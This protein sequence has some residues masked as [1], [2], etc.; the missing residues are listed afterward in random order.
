MQN[1]ANQIHQSGHHGHSHQPQDAFQVIGCQCVFVTC[2]MTRQEESIFLQSMVPNANGSQWFLF[3][4]KTFLCFQNISVK[5]S[6][7][8][9]LMLLLALSFHGVF[10]VSIELSASLT[11]LSQHPHQHQH[12]HHDHREQG[13]AVG[14]QQ[15]SSEMLSLTIAVIVHEAI[16]SFR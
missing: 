12:P 5:H 13:L 16:M 2:N 7:L 4:T 1:I 6:A 8:R 11:L 15:N 14:L 9:S 3:V 10:E